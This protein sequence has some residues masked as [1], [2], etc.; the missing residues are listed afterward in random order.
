[1]YRS[2]TVLISTPPLHLTVCGLKYVIH[3]KPL[4]SSNKSCRLQQLRELHSLKYYVQLVKHLYTPVSLGFRL[5]LEMQSSPKL[6]ID[7]SSCSEGSLNSSLQ[8]S[9][10]INPCV[11]GNLAHCYITVFLSPM[12]NFPRI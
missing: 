1:V 10:E 6:V 12:Q 9:S 5:N 2:A 3:D 11:L 8:M 4:P 7:P